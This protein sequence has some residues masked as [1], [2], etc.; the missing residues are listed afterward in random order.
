[1]LLSTIFCL[2]VLST[3]VKIILY[4]KLKKIMRSNYELYEYNGDIKA[5]YVSQKYRK[6]SS[7]DE[8]LSWSGPIT[9]GIKLIVED[10][11]FYLN[12]KV[13]YQLMFD[14]QIKLYFLKKDNE[15]VLYDCERI[16]NE[17]SPKNVGKYKQ[18]IPTMIIVAIVVFMLMILLLPILAKLGL[19]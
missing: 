18:N 16:S 11:T 3:K 13:Y 6:R 10:Q 14:K 2:F 9:N 12:E 17:K 1:M 8:P 4:I 19:M 15:C 7:L 5:I